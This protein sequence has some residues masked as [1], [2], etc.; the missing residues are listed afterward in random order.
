MRGRI[1]LAGLVVVTVAACNRSQPVTLDAPPPP[2]SSDDPSS[3]GA[4]TQS[5]APVVPASGTAAQAT[6]S[7]TQAITSQSGCAQQQAADII[8]VQHTLAAANDPCVI[9][10]RSMELRQHPERASYLECNGLK[11]Y[12]DPQPPGHPASLA[13]CDRKLRERQQRMGVAVTGMS[14]E[15]KATY[16]ATWGNSSEH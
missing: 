16:R 11:A 15:E 12:P 6:G 9:Y 3:T 14:D 8:R 10:W 2:Q 4:V 7:A 5:A 13:D 1:A